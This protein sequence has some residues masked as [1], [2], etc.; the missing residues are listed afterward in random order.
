MEAHTSY[1]SLIIVLLAAFLTPILLKKLRLTFVPVVVAE[2]VAGL[3]IGK[4]G[5]DLVN[6]EADWIVILSQL[7]FIF[8]M[9]LSG[10]EIDFSVFAGGKNRESLPNGKKEPNRFLVSL[11][12]FAVIL[13]LSYALSVAFLLLGFVTNAFFMSL[14]ISTISMGV[15]V[16]TLKETGIMKSG[17]GQIILIITII[18]DLVTMILLTVFVS[19]YQGGGGNLWFLF[20]L[21]GAGIL[22]YFVGKFFRHRTFY[23]I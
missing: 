21:V 2:I 1:T 11:I 16:P 19:L 22:L 20:I 13:G 8:L 3:I 7:G 12:I 18:A 9:F 14:V 4:T 10:V 6:P 15:V 23:F 5:F 17:P